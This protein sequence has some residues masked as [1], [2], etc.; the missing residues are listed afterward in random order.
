MT[1]IQCPL[2]VLLDSDSFIK[3]T[4]P[5]GL[6]HIKE[7]EDHISKGSCPHPPL[8]DFVIKGSGVA[9]TTPL[10][11]ACNY[12]ELDS[13]KHIVES[14]GVDVRT[15]ALGYAYPSDRCAGREYIIREATPLF[16]AAFN[17]HTAIVRYLLDKGAD[18]SAKTA[19]RKYED[20][21]PFHA[22]V[23]RNNIRIKRSICDPDSEIWKE[24]STI[25]RI[26]LEAG[27]NPSALATNGSPIWTMPLCGFEAITHLINYGMALD[28]RTNEGKQFCITG[29]ASPFK[30]TTR[31]GKKIQL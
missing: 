5:M 1:D 9:G 27:A 17:G 22:A 20:V 16:M 29:P 6:H 21:T 4:K 28:Q 11:L 18:V 25:V 26:L 3:S 2:V 15:S 8:K 10:L 14:W 13:V 7:I 24:S 12:G 31:E 19:Y 23:L 30:S